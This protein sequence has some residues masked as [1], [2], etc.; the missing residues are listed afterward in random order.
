MIKIRPS[1]NR[2]ASILIIIIQVT[3]TSVSPNV[4]LAQEANPDSASSDIQTETTAPESS[5]TTEE[6]P[7]TTPIPTPPTPPTPTPPTPAPPTPPTPPK[8][9]GESK[10]TGSESST[11][12][13]NEKTGQWENE[14]YSW[15]PVTKKS[16]SKTDTDYSYDPATGL[17]ETKKWVYDPA[18]GQYR[19]KKVFLNNEEMVSSGLASQAEIDQQ[20]QNSTDIDINNN[21]TVNNSQRSCSRSGDAEIYANT[22][23]GNAS[24][25]SAYTL[26]NILNML[27]S[28]WGD[29]GKG[30]KTFTSDIN[31]DVTGDIYINPNAIGPNANASTNQSTNNNLDVNVSDNGS[32]K[33]DI[34]LCS[35][36][37][38]SRVNSNTT[39]GDATTG[40]ADAV[41][42]I[43][44]LINSSINS[45]DSFLGVLN[46]NG[47]LDGDI[48]LPDYLDLDNL[49][50]SNT[51]PNS[52]ATSID[53]ENNELIA[54]MLSNQ[55][56]DN[57]VDNKAKSGDA[58][59]EDNNSAGSAETGGSQTNVTIMN[60]T[61]REIIG[62]SSLLVFVNVLGTWVGFIVDA[63]T[64]SNTAALG[65]G[66]DS[67][68]SN[69][70]EAN[71]SAKINI[72]ENKG[73]T[74][75]IEVASETGDAEVSEN[76]VAGSAKTG[77]A[78]ASTNLLN[79]IN[80]KLTLKNW[81]GILFI[82]VF[83]SWHGSF[84]VDT[85]RGTR[86][87]ATV[88]ETGQ[89]PIQQAQVF[90]FVPST[91]SGVRVNPV[92]STLGS[93]TDGNSTITLATAQNPKVSSP[94]S[95]NVV[96][97][98]RT[99]QRRNTVLNWLSFGSA[100]TLSLLGVEQ[101]SNLKQ[102]MINMRRERKLSPLVSDK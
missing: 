96:E 13:F 33:N 57:N 90:S 98:A 66:I 9:T 49:L 62:D 32:I 91:G 25:G 14:H 3:F 83:G 88:A 47:N 89:V 17:W 41:A 48:L 82:N 99:A 45:G 55:S 6:S 97:Q 24:S 75:N 74:N 27:G 46:I 65:S 37:G 71:N 53:I 23:A 29:L 78:T 101:L 76:T 63:P 39:A 54:D 94:Q 50:T 21:A 86:A 15:D 36:S 61:G 95:N 4:I 93:D 92:S 84:G 26:A 43:L 44:N 31:G 38:S 18:K 100:L 11:Y 35:H 1:I 30:V 67:N 79:M 102:K 72:E 40:N 28:S 7:V 8:S 87:L 59:V 52:N 73:I 22:H 77:K 51:G 56:I 19:P 34:K 81:F 60:L 69:Y 2:L 16:T 5:P 10:P 20:V 64:G 85:E 68:V 12:T 42:N 58:T 70:N 80:S